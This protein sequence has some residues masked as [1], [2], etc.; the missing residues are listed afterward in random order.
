MI[1]RS[2]NK[3]HDYIMEHKNASD[4]IP[5]ELKIKKKKTRTTLEH[6]PQVSNHK[7]QG[8]K[9]LHD[10]FTRHKDASDRIP[11]Q[12]MMKEKTQ[13]WNIKISGK[14]SQDTRSKKVTRLFH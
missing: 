4:K 3:L 13:L 9:K 7:T 14:L 11:Y 8:T 1:T 10:Y 2:K 5:C 6:R 12:L